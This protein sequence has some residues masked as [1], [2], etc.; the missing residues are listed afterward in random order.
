[1]SSL[2]ITGGLGFIGKH[3]IKNF[4]SKGHTIVVLEHPS[5]KSVSHIYPVKYVYADIT[6]YSELSSLKLPKIDVV[7]HLAGQSSGPKSFSIPEID[8]S[9]N[10]L[11][12]LN[13]IKFCK[14]NCIH[15]LLFASSFVVY[16]N[17]STEILEENSPTKPASVYG[18]SKLYA[19]NLLRTF[20]E[21]NGIKWN[22]LRMFNVYGPGQDITKPDQGIVGIFLNQLLS[23]PIVNVKGTISR[24]RDLVYIDDVVKGWDCVLE[25]SSYNEVFNVGSGS[26]TTIEILI[27]EIAS[28]L[29]LSN[30]LVINEIEPTPGDVNGAFAS[31]EKISSLTNYKPT[32]TLREGLSRMVEMYS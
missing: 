14:I 2:L 22:S 15:R 16:G 21:P 27:K 24:F 29:D 7:I 3:L 18:S 30:E 20:A 4:I 25:S 9:L 32:T 12:T 28:L 13:M 5:F 10:A 1:M 19:E 6:N 17:S 8:L 23:S 31:L 26:K 11:G